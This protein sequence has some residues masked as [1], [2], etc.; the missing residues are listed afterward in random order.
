MDIKE[1][2]KALSNGGTTGS[3]GQEKQKKKKGEINREGRE[4]AAMVGEM[5]GFLLPRLSRA[6]QD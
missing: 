4:V 6:A 3:Y 5:L 2:D 1:G